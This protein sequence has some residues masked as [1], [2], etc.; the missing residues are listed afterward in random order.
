MMQIF[1]N[2]I[3]KSR[4]DNTQYVLFKSLDM[5]CVSDKRKLLELLKDGWQMMG[6]YH[7]GV[8]YEKYYIT[9]SSVVKSFENYLN[10]KVFKHPTKSDVIHNANTVYIH[11]QIYYEPIT[12]KIEGSNVGITFFQ[13]NGNQCV[14]EYFRIE[15]SENVELIKRFLNVFGVKQD[16]DSLIDLFEKEMEARSKC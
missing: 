7:N 14:P 4:T 11:F 2:A 8:G 13:H 16:N 5:L 1:V 12:C 10:D 3:E 6:E 15:N 9:D